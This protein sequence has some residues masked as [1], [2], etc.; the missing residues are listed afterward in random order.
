[1][2]CGHNRKV[3]IASYREA[4]F[5]PDADRTQRQEEAEAT[6]RVMADINAR[7]GYQLVELPQVLVEEGVAFVVIHLSEE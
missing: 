6:G 2:T 4:L 1:M 3:F 5:G 7:S